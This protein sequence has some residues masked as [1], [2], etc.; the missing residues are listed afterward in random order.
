MLLVD[1]M[2]KGSDDDLF[3]KMFGDMLQGGKK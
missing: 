2:G 1:K 3:T